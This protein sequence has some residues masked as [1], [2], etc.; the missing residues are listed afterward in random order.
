MALGCRNNRIKQSSAQRLVFKNSL[1]VIRYAV[2][3]LQSNVVSH[4]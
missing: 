3:V 2:V 4:A 1:I